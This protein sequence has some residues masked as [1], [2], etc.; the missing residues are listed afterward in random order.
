MFIKILLLLLLEPFV[1]LGSVPRLAS[2]QNFECGV[3]PVKCGDGWCCIFGEVCQAS[4]DAVFVCVD[5]ILTNSD[6]SAVTNPA[7]NPASFD[8][9]ISGI[10]SSATQP[11]TFTQNGTTQTISFSI[12]AL[13]TSSIDVSGSRDRSTITPAPSASAR[14]STI[15]PTTTSESYGEASVA[16][17]KG[18]WIGP[19]LGIVLMFVL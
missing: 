4:P 6:G 2:R 8:S 7:Q 3:K 5:S 10:I 19:I 12:S 17:M 1:A 18:W 16:I 13:S 9:L 11:L 15:I 14:T